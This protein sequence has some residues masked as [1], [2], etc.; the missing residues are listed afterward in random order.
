M[1]GATGTVGRNTLDVAGRHPGR[2]RVHAL[3][4]QRDAAGL[5]ALCQQHRPAV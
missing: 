4:A 2:L 1:L 3:T 5:L